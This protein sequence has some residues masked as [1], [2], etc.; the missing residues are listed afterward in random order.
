MNHCS[1]GPMVGDSAVIKESWEV[2]VSCVACNT[3][4]PKT[5]DFAILRGV[6][7][8]YEVWKV[9]SETF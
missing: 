9:R 1:S 6:S 2:L 8:A 4:A 5:R 7:P 3:R